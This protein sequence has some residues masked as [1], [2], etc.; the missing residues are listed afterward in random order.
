VSGEQ[1]AGAVGACF[2]AAL[3]WW[4]PGAAGRAVGQ[5]EHESRSRCRRRGGRR[6]PFDAGRRGRAS[7]AATPLRGGS[8]P[9]ALRRRAQGGAGERGDAAQDL[10]RQAAQAV[11]PCAEDPTPCSAGTFSARA[12]RDGSDR[13]PLRGA[14]GSGIR[15]EAPVRESLARHVAAYAPG[16]GP[17]RAASGATPPLKD[18]AATPQSSVPAP[19]S[20]RA[21]APP[22]APRRARCA[23]RDDDECAAGGNAGCRTAGARTGIATTSSQLAKPAITTGPRKSARAAVRLRAMKGPAER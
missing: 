1:R 11:P 22:P 23:Q 8:D 19:A 5:Q 15:P 2:T 9:A 3:F 21:P 14:G 10:G 18:H 12:R 13:P 17:H 6:G 7:T 20:F 4:P 16:Q